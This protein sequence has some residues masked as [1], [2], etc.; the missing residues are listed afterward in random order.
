MKA[1]FLAVSAAAVL[2]A[3]SASEAAAPRGAVKDFVD[4]A[5]LEAGHRLAAAGVDLKDQQVTVK[6]T[7]SSDGLRSVQVVNSSASRDTE[8]A[9]EQVLKRLAVKDVPAGLV[10]ASVTIPLGDGAVVQARNP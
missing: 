7:V 1:M 9:V 3:A 6:A 5:H 4:R 8:R 10:G 2:F